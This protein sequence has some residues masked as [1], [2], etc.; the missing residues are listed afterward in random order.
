MMRIWAFILWAVL[1]IL[2]D[3]LG[4]VV[5]DILIPDWISRTREARRRRIYQEGQTETSRAPSMT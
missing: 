5:L 1:C 4:V 2:P 3:R